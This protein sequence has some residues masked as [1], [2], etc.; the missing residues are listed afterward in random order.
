MALVDI[1]NHLY[2]DFGT[3]TVSVSECWEAQNRASMKSGYRGTQ[4]VTK[5]GYTCQ[6]WTSQSPHSHSYTLVTSKLGGG[7][8]VR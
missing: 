7:G 8:G 3:K 5:N 6:K 4:S 2:S 1:P